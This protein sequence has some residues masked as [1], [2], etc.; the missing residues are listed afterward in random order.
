M[1]TINAQMWS[2]NYDH[3]INLYLDRPVSHNILESRQRASTVKPLSDI[4]AE[5]LPTL[6]PLISDKWPSIQMTGKLWETQTLSL[7]PLNTL[8][9]R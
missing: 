4:L 7:L 3:W 1:Q 5:F 6:F 8:S 9:F 2:H